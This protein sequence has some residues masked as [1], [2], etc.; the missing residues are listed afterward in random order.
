MAED[1][2]SRRLSLEAPIVALFVLIL[3]WVPFPYGSNRPWALYVLAI[4]LGAV[5]TFWSGAVICACARLTPLTRK[6]SLPAA[7]LGIAL[8]FAL[9]QALDLT[10]IDR[11]FGGTRF[12]AL[13]SHPVWT[14]ASHAFG[15]PSAAYISVDPQRTCAAIVVTLISVGAFVLSFELARDAGQARFLLQATIAIGSAYAVLGFAELF[16]RTDVHSWLM[17]DPKPVDVRLTGPFIN[18]NHFATLAGMGAIGA[19]GLLVEALT[20]SVVWNRGGKILARTLLQAVSGANAVWFAAALLL[21]SAVLLT[22][23]RGGIAAFFVGIV[24]LVAALVVKGGGASGGSAPRWTLPITLLVVI[25]VAGWIAA[26]PIVERAQLQGAGDDSRAAIARATLKGIA[27]APFLGNGFGA[28]E[29]YYPIYSDGT[30]V[31][32]VDQAHNDYL[33]TLADLGLP[34]GLAFI[35]APAILALLCL[36]GSM[37]RNRDRIFPAIGVAVSALVG[38]HALV[39]FSLQIPAVSVFFATLLGLGVSQAWS[40]AQHRN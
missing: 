7:C 31:G 23:S 17:A 16:L 10:I 36:R 15:G 2:Y 30:V 18:P 28:F 3:A 4:A 33:E 6:L 40:T 37:T 34:A 14:M 11:M 39:D 32:D 24:V 29:R 19:F 5:L 8:G 12:A 26:A 35:G 1:G 25:G 9:L 20:R 38:T 27:S 21:L 22:Q 13:L